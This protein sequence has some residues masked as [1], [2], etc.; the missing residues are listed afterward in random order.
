MYLDAYWS[1]QQ[2]KSNLTFQR[3]F[4]VELE[5]RIPNQLQTGKFPN[6]RD[7]RSYTQTKPMEEDH[8]SN[9]GDMIINN[10]GS[11]QR[12]HSWALQIHQFAHGDWNLQV[13]TTQLH[14]AIK[15]LRSKLQIP[16][17]HYICRNPMLLENMGLEFMGIIYSSVRSVTLN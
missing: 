1:N 17:Q 6:L 14:H 3:S 13:H 12:K 16:I 2:S 8:P 7:W 10:I 11:S 4:P 15:D 9:L 5:V